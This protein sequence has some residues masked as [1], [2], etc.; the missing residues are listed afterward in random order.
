MALVLRVNAQD[1]IGA[2]TRRAFGGWLHR[3]A[4]VVLVVIA[5]CGPGAAQERVTLNFSN[6]EIEAVV[7]AIS[8]FTG[9]VFVVDP[10]VKG[11]LSLTIEQ[12]LSPE[13]ALAALTAALRL[14]GVVLV[15]SGGIVRV[16]PEADAK[17]Q[18]GAVQFGPTTEAPRGDQLV[19]RLRTEVAERPFHRPGPEP[20][21]RRDDV[22]RAD[23]VQPKLAELVGGDREPEVDQLRR[24]GDEPDQ[25]DDKQTQAQGKKKKKPPPKPAPDQPQPKRKLNLNVGDVLIFEEVISPTTGEPSDADRKHRHAV[26]LIK[27]TPGVDPLHNQPVV[28]IEWA[29]DDALP[30]TL[31]LSAVS[32]PPITAVAALWNQSRYAFRWSSVQPSPSGRNENA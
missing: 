13:Q 2:S 3:L 1:R 18:G 4:A 6:T 22:E 25:D 19:T 20:E 14:Q 24:P 16:V 27:V 21:P 12:P 30:F 9:K 7:R 23:V 15:E 10:R 17:L 11:T 31:C 28:E 32:A 8:K 5:V 26:R 29:E